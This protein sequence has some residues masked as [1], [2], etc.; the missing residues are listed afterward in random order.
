MKKNNEKAVK[1]K[2]ERRNII[3]TILMFVLGVIIVIPSIIGM[4]VSLP[5]VLIIIGL[6][7]M[8]VF[9]CM[10]GAG[11]YLIKTSMYKGEKVK[12]PHCKDITSQNY[13]FLTARMHGSYKCTRCKEI[14][15]VQ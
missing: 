7:P 12:C 13:G 9:I 15:L 4:I 10:G 14:V 8:F 11:M 2:K 3:E 1:M 6:I 5:F